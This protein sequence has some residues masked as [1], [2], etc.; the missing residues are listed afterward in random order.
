MNR[1]EF[2]AIAGAGAIG[3]G[4]SAEVTPGGLGQTALPA[5][6]VGEYDVCVVGGSCTGVFAA[7]RAAEAGM[8]VALL[9]KNMFFGGTATAGFVPI[10]HSLFSLDGK[11][12]VAGGLTQLLI[13]RMVASGKADCCEPT[14]PRSVFAYAI[15][16]ASSL[17]LELDRL[18]KEHPS[19]KTYFGAHFAAAETDRPGHVTR[20]IFE[21]K[22][23]RRSIAAKFFID[24]SGDGDLLAR[25]GFET[26]K[27][28]KCDMQ[29]HTLC[30][31]LTGV[32]KVY[33]KHKDFSFSEMM[34][35]RRG[36]KLKHVFQWWS[37][38]IG[39]PELTF[40]AA[41]RVGNCDPTE[42]DDLTEGMFEGRAQ[43]ERLV[44]AINREFPTEG[45]GVA[46]AAIAP[47]MG[48]RESRHAKCLY[49]VTGEDVLTGR[50]FKDVIAQGTYRIDIHEGKG[51]TLRYLDGRE[52]KMVQ[53]PANGSVETKWT[54]WRPEGK[55]PKCY[56]IP[57]R[58]IVPVGSEN[59][60]CAGRMLDASRDAYG[61]LRVMVNCNQMGEAAGRAAAKAVKEGLKASE[62][63]PGFFI[64]SVAVASPVI[65]RTALFPG[66][67][68]KFCKIQPSMASDGK[69]TALLTYQK[70]LLTGSD[71]FYGQYISKSTDDG[72]TW[73]EPKKIEALKADPWKGF[74][75]ERYA[76]PH[77][78]R[79]TGRF[80]AIGAADIFK[81]D[82]A[83][84]QKTVDGEAYCWPLFVTV[85]AEKGDYVKCEKLEFP[86]AYE[87]CMAFGQIH[88][89]ENGDVLIPFYYR[90]PKAGVKQKC[91]II[92]YAFDGEKLKVVKAGTPMARMD[93]ARGLGEPSVIEYRGKFYVTLRSDEMGM[94]AV[95]ENR[96]DYSEPIPWKWTDGNL[97]GN[98]NTQQHWVKTGGRLFLAYTR[99]TPNNGHVFRN[100]A[101]VFL[102]EVDTEKMALKRET[103]LAIVPER[104]A[105]LGNFCVVPSG[106][107]QWLVTAEWMQPIGCEKRGSDN[108]LWFVRIGG[109][110]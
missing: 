104:G 101:P 17:I 14:N 1:R 10:W 96:L 81:D 68:G 15:F 42:A 54:R 98:A 11:E 29:A 88:E 80:F 35:P 89:C 31:L 63:Y 16:N 61:A 58:S 38:V 85:D 75:V 95:S 32:G 92:R 106:D 79:K 70:L 43:L 93:L 69:G 67:D 102:A 90:E 28:P 50:E 62:A 44:A 24:C 105:R 40:L 53:N 21:D 36:A 23:G 87:F 74:R 55:N 103:E 84:Y 110:F 7:V 59:V 12:R 100:R 33:E 66:F 109:G 46:I 78:H 99:V 18:V 47:E 45:P 56:Q 20:V 9:E 4:L 73:S 52:E 65:E 107:E 3:G 27:L 48:L 51:I 41:T 57:Y 71:V 64:G 25:A 6:E 76:N 13:D 30:A 60:L 22:S 49:Q 5:S 72:K 19:I 91:V 82:G 39:C 94:V 34:H 108:S 86:F 8:R 83:P 26:W 77:Y 2:L 37:P 97:I